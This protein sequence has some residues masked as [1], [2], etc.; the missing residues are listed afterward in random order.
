MFHLSTR[1]RM[2]ILS[3]CYQ[4]N[5]AY[6]FFPSIVII[7]IRLAKEAKKRDMKIITITDSRVS[8]VVEFSDIVIPITLTQGNT[9][10]KGP[11]TLSIINAILFE[12]IN[13]M[14]EVGE[15]PSTYKYFI[16]DES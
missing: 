5:H 12:I 9:F 3:N 4:K 16:K 6:S 13:K 2:W 7:Q 8:P 14:E 1:D 15:L 10:S 11:A